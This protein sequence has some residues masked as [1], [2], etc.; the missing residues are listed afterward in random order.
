[1]EVN[2][3]KHLIPLFSTIYQTSERRVKF[4]VNICL[5]VFRGPFGYV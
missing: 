2:E 1:M 5:F 3:I 4:L